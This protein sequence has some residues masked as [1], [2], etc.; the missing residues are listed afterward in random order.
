VQN[1]HGLAP[2]I[3]DDIVIHQGKFARDIRP[4]LS[5]IQDFLILGLTGR[6]SEDVRSIRRSKNFPL[7][8]LWAKLVGCKYVESPY[9]NNTQRMF[10]RL[11]RMYCGQNTEYLELIKLAFA[12]KVNDNGK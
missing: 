7:E 5:L 12:K 1:F 9:A 2:E 6:S 11:T 10:E 8:K 3:Q 4:S